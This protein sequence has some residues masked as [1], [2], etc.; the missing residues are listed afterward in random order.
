M[1]LMEQLK[2]SEKNL[3]RCHSVYYRSNMDWTEIEPRPS[4]LVIKCIKFIL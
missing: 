4:G 3:S 2:Y 1:I